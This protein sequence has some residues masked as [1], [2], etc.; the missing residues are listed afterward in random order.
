MIQEFKGIAVAGRYYVAT[1]VGNYTKDMF[2]RFKLIS[3]APWRMSVPPTEKRKKPFPWSQ[4]PQIFVQG[5]KSDLVLRYSRQFNVPVFSISSGLDDG[6]NQ[7]QIDPWVPNLGDHGIPALITA[8]QCCQE[9][10]MFISNTL[11]VDPDTMPPGQ[12]TDV[13]KAEAHGFDKRQSFR[14]RK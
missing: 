13:Q 8:E 10:S 2:G 14:H 12:Q 11:V 1:R 9:I 5:S 6:M 7:V 4:E 3:A